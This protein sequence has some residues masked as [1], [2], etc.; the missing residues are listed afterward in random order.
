[1]QFMIEILNVLYVA[2]AV[3]LLFGAAIFVHEFGHYW[4]ARRR[5]MKVEAFA[6]GFGPKI[7]GWVEDGIE[8]SW[9]WIPAGGYVKLPQMITSEALE[10][11]TSTPHEAIPPAP[12]LS[13][14]LVAVAGPLMNLVFAVVIAAVIYVVGLP[15][16]VNPSIIGYVDPQ[17]PEAKLG[18]REGDQIVAVNG[19]PVD[20]WQGVMMATLVARTAAVPVTIERAGHQRTYQLKLV[21][22][23]AFGL[24]MLNLDPR[25]HPEVIQVQPGDPGA[26]AGL[27]PKDLIASFAGVPIVS[28]E[29]LIDLIQKRAGKASQIRVRRGPSTVTLQITPQFDPAT[30]KGRIGV[31]LGNSVA[32]YRIERPGPAPWTL[33]GQVWD[34]MATTFSALLHSK[35]TGVG[36]KDL[37][38]PVGILAM[39]ATQVNTDYR[40]ALRFLVLLNIDLAV[41]NL[42]PIPVLDGGHVLMA[43]IEKIRRRP[44]SVRFVEYTTTAFAGLII[45]FMLYVTI[46]GDFGRLSLFKSMFTQENRI[47]A[48]T[49]TPA[50]STPPP[51]AR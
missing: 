48:P 9:R 3:V 13:K 16:L 8:Y 36:A 44:L 40:L 19:K 2:F 37:S 17:S 34:E 24:K 4:V 10:G 39:L 29:Q 42:L 12:P 20:S 47:E 14:I 27:E 38:G 21:T 50:P 26:A 35:Q 18:I 43:I 22:N 7:I 30:R 32:I 46:V 6:I 5:G 28:R 33:I 45:L 49:P 23:R 25:D 41:L 51:G 15:V 1:M 31:M 11:E